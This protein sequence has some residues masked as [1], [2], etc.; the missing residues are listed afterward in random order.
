MSHP[1][2]RQA[3]LGEIITKVS[4]HA[5]TARSATD[6][7]YFAA[8]QTLPCHA[9]AARTDWPTAGHHR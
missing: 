2:R 5:P 4:I 7:I 3:P 8:A 6:P 9:R 1:A